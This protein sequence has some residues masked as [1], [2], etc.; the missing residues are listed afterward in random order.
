[1]ENAVSCGGVVIF[2]GKILLLYKNYH[3]RYEGWVLPKGTVENGETHEQTALREVHEE[4]GVK[5][6]II[7]SAQYDMEQATLT[8]PFDGVIANLFE[9][10]YNMP[11]TSEPFCRVIN[12]GN[13]EVDFTVLE[14]ETESC[15]NGSLR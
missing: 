7:E 4:T 14:N 13:M 6:T 2:R 12:A 3:N 15:R 9:K 10:R 5:A 1:M 11:K 8:A